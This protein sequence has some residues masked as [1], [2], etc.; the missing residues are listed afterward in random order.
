M[1]RD[2][3]LLRFGM[4][5][6]E[7]KTV[8]IQDTKTLRDACAAVKQ[9][10]KAEFSEAAVVEAGLQ[11]LIEKLSGLSLPAER[12]RPLVLKCQVAA[13]RQLLADLVA[14]GYPVEHVSV[15]LDA[16]TGGVVIR[17]DG[18]EIEYTAGNPAE[19]VNIIN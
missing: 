3:V 4:A 6:K 14:L 16:R 7:S 17:H 19:A 11:S 5:Q 2:R 8:R 15:D 12:V 1:R 13:M 18:D 10:L 9:T